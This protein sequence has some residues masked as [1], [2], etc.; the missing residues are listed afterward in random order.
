MAFYNALCY[1][2]SEAVLSISQRHPMPLAFGSTRGQNGRMI[3]RE[4][5]TVVLFCGDRPDMSM[6][7]RPL[8]V[9]C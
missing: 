1:G 3:D 8:E 5:P 6:A 7:I 9:P 2:T 4:M